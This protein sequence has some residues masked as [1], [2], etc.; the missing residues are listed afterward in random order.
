MLYH[1][2]YSLF[3]GMVKLISINRYFVLLFIDK[4][5]KLRLNDNQ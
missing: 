2:K 5:D 4:L 3:N 1:Y